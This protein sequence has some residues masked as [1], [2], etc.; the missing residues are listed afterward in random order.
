MNLKELSSP[1]R[2]YWDL[3]PTE[4]VNSAAC[5]RIAR[6]AV[7]GK[8]LSLQITD[9]APQLSRACIAA[10]DELKDTMM[11]VSLVAS[12]SALDVPVLDHLNKLS[13]IAV[14]IPASS[15]R[16]LDVIPQLSAQTESKP[17]TGVSFPVTRANFRELP[18]VLSFCIEH[19]IGHLLLPMQRLVSG[20]QCFTFTAEERAELAARLERI[21][22]PSWLRITIH[23][24]FLWR[25]FFPKV[26][27]PNGGCQAANTLLYISPEADVYPCPTLP[28]KIGSLL[29]SSLGDLIRSE[30]K[31]VLRAGILVAP[32]ECG[33]CVGLVECKGGCRGRAYH[34]S[35]S[36]NMPDPSCR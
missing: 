30:A 7:A 22:K 33:Q 32:K 24:P 15:M 9:T 2:L 29:R 17:M 35:N 1:I 8:F 31:K 5:R 20:E 26:E 34:Q 36:L 25:V 11:A 3:G 19:R 16:E 12:G 28:I 13:V 27:F 21:E 4:Q 6:E 10:L 23:D 14:F 18:Q